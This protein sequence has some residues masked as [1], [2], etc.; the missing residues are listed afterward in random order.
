[1]IIHLG[2]VSHVSVIGMRFELHFDHGGS[3][4]RRFQTVE[5]MVA[6]IKDWQAKTVDT[7]MSERAPLEVAD[8]APFVSGLATAARM[9]AASV[10]QKA[11]GS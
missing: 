5:E 9:K 1:M 6:A 10:R 2:R 11:G 4:M 3:H 7:E 8:P